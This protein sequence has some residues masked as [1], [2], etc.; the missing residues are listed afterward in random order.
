M[1]RDRLM[2]RR[3]L[4]RSTGCRI[5]G[6]P[7]WG[8]AFGRLGGRVP[9][10][11]L[12]NGEAQAWAARSSTVARFLVFSCRAGKRTRAVPAAR[13]RSAGSNSRRQMVDTG[14]T[15]ALK[16]EPGA[17]VAG[18]PSL[19]GPARARCR[20]VRGQAA[21]KLDATDASLEPRQHTLM[22]RMLDRLAPFAQ[23]AVFRRRRSHRRAAACRLNRACQYTALEAGIGRRPAA[24]LR[25]RES[26]RPHR[27]AFQ[28]LLES[29]R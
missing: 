3:A 11:S 16:L 21:A 29:A 2:E 13:P 24:N 1:A 4:R 6:D 5:A 23:A 9:T 15:P 27:P 12:G 7:G 20:S 17:S 10:R 25:S 26:E 18:V 28:A 8:P 22:T 14:A 19:P